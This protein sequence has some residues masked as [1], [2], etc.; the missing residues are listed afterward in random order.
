ME[1]GEGRAWKRAKGCTGEGWWEGAWEGCR[2]CKGVYEGTSDMIAMSRL[3]RRMTM[4]T[5]KVKKKMIFTVML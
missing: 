4:T 5:E 3:R 2:C 1:G